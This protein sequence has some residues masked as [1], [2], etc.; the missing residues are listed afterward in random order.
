MAD[1]VG[2]TP[3]TGATVAADDVGGVLVQRV[4]AT[5]GI[6]GTAGDVHG[7]NPLP[8]ALSGKAATS[9]VTS[10]AGSASTVSLLAANAARLGA[11]VYNDSTAK[12]YLKLGATAS[13]TSHTVQIPAG[14]YYELPA[15]PPYTGAVDGIWASAAGAARITELS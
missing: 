11:A 8:V 2:Y 7:G 1:N 12:L 15:V 3:G 13:A 4:K 5:F 9:V 14:G 10:V 6:D